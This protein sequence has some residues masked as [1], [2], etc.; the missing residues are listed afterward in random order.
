MRQDGDLDSVL[1]MASHRNKL[2]S[3]IAVMGALGSCMQEFEIQILNRSNVVV[4]AQSER[5]SAAIQLGESAT[6]P[7]PQGNSGHTLVVKIGRRTV[8]YWL[9]FDIRRHGERLVVRSHILESYLDRSLRLHIPAANSG[10]T[11]EI[12][13]AGKCAETS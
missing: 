9:G 12:V 1:E 7:F 8:C 11:E 3:M 4:L 5:Q 6:L 10:D 2:I 13:P